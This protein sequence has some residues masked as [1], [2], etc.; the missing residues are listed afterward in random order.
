MDFLGVGVPELVVILVLALIF[1]GPKELP[2]LAEKAGKFLRDLRMMS[3]GFTTEWRREIGTAARL[4]ELQ[5]VRQELT[6]T[7]QMLRDT[8]RE[9]RSSTAFDVVTS[10]PSTGDKPPAPSAAPS[11]EA[12]AENPDGND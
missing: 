1:V 2:Q 10:P 9:I 11:P 3:E 12:A 6:A 5:Q 8:N 4:E 7:Q